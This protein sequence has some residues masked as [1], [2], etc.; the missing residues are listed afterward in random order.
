LK[1]AQR[2]RVVSTRWRGSGICGG[3]REWVGM[4]S[5]GGDRWNGLCT[6]WVILNE[7]GWQRNWTWSTGTGRQFSKPGGETVCIGTIFWGKGC[8]RDVTVRG[9]GVTVGGW[10]FPVGNWGVTVGD[11]GVTVVDITV[12]E[13]DVT[14]GTQWLSQRRD[15]SSQW[16]ELGGV[17]LLNMMGR[18]NHPHQPGKHGPENGPREPGVGG[19]DPPLA[20]AA[21]D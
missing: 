3:R 15:S 18:P 10:G 11:W 12:E 8:H 19:V 20:A 5:L 2:I 1:N 4:V 13:I 14:N 7:G 17:G 21:L 9:W 6:E 16:L